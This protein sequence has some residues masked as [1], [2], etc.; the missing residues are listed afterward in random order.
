M[1]NIFL[2]YKIV[3]EKESRV[4][5]ELEYGGNTVKFGRNRVVE[6]Q[7]CNMTS[8]NFTGHVQHI[9]HVKLIL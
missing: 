3:V 6:I 9:V 7:C 5:V 4:S 2:N 1:S 8:D